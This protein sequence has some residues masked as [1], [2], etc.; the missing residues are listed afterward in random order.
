[1]GRRQDDDIGLQLVE[2]LFDTVDGVQ[3]FVAMIVRPVTRFVHRDRMRQH[4]AADEAS[5]AFSAVPYDRL[6][7]GAAELFAAPVC[8]L[9]RVRFYAGRRVTE[10]NNSD[11][12]NIAM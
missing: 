8:K 12:S 5:L 4:R 6:R 3:R 7:V 2:P 1:M 11:H 10:W 9:D